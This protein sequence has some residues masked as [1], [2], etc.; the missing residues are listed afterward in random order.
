MKLLDLNDQNGTRIW[1]GSDTL[2][3]AEPAEHGLTL[4]TMLTGGSGHTPYT[5]MPVRDS[6]TEIAAKVPRGPGGRS[7][8]L[9]VTQD[10]GG[11]RPSPLLLFTEHIVTAGQSAKRNVLVMAGGALISTRDRVGPLL[12]RED[13]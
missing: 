3:M 2:I 7:R 11:N 10:P 6:L 13:A 8:C 9:I 4:L 5:F 12:A 1:V